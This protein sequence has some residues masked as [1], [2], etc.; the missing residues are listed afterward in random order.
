M[1]YTIIDVQLLRNV[2][3]ACRYLPT[4]AVMTDDEQFKPPPPVDCYMGLYGQQTQVIFNMFDSIATCKCLLYHRSPTLI[5]LQPNISKTAGHMSS[6][7]VLLSG[8]WIGAQLIQKIVLV[9]QFFHQLEKYS[10]AHDMWT[11][12][13]NFKH[14]LAIAPVPSRSH[15]PSIGAKVSLPSPACVQIWALRP[16]TP[17][18]NAMDDDVPQRDPAEIRC[19]MVL[20]LEGGPAQDIKWCPLPAHDRVCSLSCSITHFKAL[21]TYEVGRCNAYRCTPETWDTSRY[22]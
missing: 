8:E 15:A 19:E 6:M 13:R 2:R 7:Q 1:T 11:I 16:S 22:L 4:D 18:E 17:D 14:Y 12:A 20:C 9:R 3:D 10:T 5:S 21:K